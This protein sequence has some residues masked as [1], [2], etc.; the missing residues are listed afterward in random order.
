VSVG[1][2]RKLDQSKW[3][4]TRVRDAM[5]PAEVSLTVGPDESAVFALQRAT[6]NGLGRLAVLDG[7]R[8][9]G[10]LSLKDIRHVLALNG[11]GQDATAGGSLP[12]AARRA[13]LKRVA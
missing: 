7:D 9:A 3:A 4:T 2:L 8:L 6:S 13:R 12:G 1:E 10:Y 5:R 11:L